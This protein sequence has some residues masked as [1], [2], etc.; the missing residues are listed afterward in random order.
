MA[1]P[2][3]GTMVRYHYSTGVDVPGVVIAT[4]A[5][6]NSDMTTFYGN[7]GPGVGEVF[8]ATW[9]TPNGPNLSMWPNVAEGTSVGQF[10]RLAM[11][12]EDV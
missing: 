6:W 8:L 4:A 7:S 1:V 5:N 11:E 3:M 2:G 9:Q 10:S 12:A